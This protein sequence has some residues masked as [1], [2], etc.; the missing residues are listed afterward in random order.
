MLSTRQI[1]VLRDDAA[2]TSGRLARIMWTRIGGVGVNLLVLLLILPNFL[3]R[4]P[5]PLLLQSVK[6]A[7]IG[8]PV[9]MLSVL[10]MLLP[11]SSV[12]PALMAL[13]PTAILIPIAFWRVAALKS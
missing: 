3:C 9:L 13:L 5:G 6:C 2:T 7:A 10:V 8:V 11:V 4:L 12:S 1:G